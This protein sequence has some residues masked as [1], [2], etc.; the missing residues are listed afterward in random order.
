[1]TLEQIQGKRDKIAK[2]QTEFCPYCKLPLLQMPI[3]FDI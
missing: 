1:M 3:G 2:L